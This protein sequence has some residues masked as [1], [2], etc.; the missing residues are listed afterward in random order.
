MSNF[1]IDFVS[2][3]RYE[4]LLVEISYRQQRL[5]IINKE[6]G[7]DNLEIEF[8]SDIRILTED[9][10]MKFPL[11]EFESVLKEACND[12]KACE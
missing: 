2:D 11:A 9:V 10:V 8:V 5:C 3:L 6:H 1:E 7:N 12:L 4:H